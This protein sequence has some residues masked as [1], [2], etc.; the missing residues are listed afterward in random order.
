MLTI[1]DYT[2]GDSTKIVF[3]NCGQKYDVERILEELERSGNEDYHQIIA[4]LDR[5]AKHG[6]VFNARK[7]KRLT[8][9]ANPLCEFRARHGTRII[10]FYDVTTRDCI[11][12]THAFIKKTDGTDRQEIGRGKERMN[13]YYEWRNAN[14]PQR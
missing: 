5:T 8:G 11:V 13:L 1:A 4:H 10:W 7:T 3:M 14:K 9:N 12:C 6:V 2:T